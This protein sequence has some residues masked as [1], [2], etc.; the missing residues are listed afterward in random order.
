MVAIVLLAKRSVDGL[1]AAVFTALVIGLFGGL[2]DVVG[3]A[4]SQI[5]FQW[6]TTAAQVIIAVSIGVSAG[7]LIGSI[8]AFR[9]NRP[10]PVLEDDA[11]LEVAP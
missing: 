2:A 5:P 9:I 8:L 1:F 7:V 11:P 4:R 10:L 6:G 3:L